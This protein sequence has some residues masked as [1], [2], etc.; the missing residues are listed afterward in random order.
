MAGRRIGLCVLVLAAA[1]V[2][3]VAGDFQ[4]FKLTN[5]LTYAIA[6]LG[7][8]IL[9]GY[10]GQIS[11]GHGAFYAI[12]AYSA[13]ILTVHAEIPHWAA[14]PVA[15]AL[16]L[17]A[18]IAFALPTL[19]LGG[20]HLAMATFALGAVLPI[21]VKHKAIEHWTGGGQGIALDKPPVPFGL[22]M[23]FDQWMYL[24]TLFVLVVCFAVAANLLQG[25][26]GRAILAIRDNPIAA[27]AMGI[28]A[29]YY[30]TAAFGI[31]AMFT[32]IAGAL[33]A[34]ALQYVA[35]GLFGIFLSF[36]F[37]IGVA[38]GG[39]ATLSGAIYGAIFLQLIFLVVGVTA[40]TLNTS[41]VFLIYGIVLILVVHFMP[42]GVASLV[43]RIRQSR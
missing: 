9:V 12:G 5:V 24:L 11:L 18:G 2:P 3:L 29:A 28:R 37:L 42:G 27:E 43:E 31:S 23:S 40:K 30:K 17:A 34:L 16:C 41:N 33:A 10:N 22:P 21:V 20:M 1:C 4:L 15:G 14:I 13:A 8:N 32:G 36:G 38:V 25:R 7:L 26:I 39:F 35:P 6:L 19:R